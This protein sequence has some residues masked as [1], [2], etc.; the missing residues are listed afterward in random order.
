MT[1]DIFI[2]THTVSIN[3]NLSYLFNIRKDFRMQMNANEFKEPKDI[4]QVIFSK[5]NL[6]VFH[7]KDVENNGVKIHN[8]L[9]STKPNKVLLF[10]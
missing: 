3:C 7:N 6:S 9:V 10:Q 5:L 1:H 8:K 4:K 2:K